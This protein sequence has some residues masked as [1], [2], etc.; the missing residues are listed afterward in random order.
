MSRT[1]STPSSVGSITSRKNCEA[2]EN[3]AIRRSQIDSVE[4][5][6]F[7]FEQQSAQLDFIVQE[8]EFLMWYDSII[9]I[10][11]DQKLSDLFQG[12]HSQTFNKVKKSL[13]PSPLLKLKACFFRQV[14][15]VPPQPVAAK[16]TVL[17]VAVHLNL[18]S[19]FTVVGVECF[20]HCTTLAPKWWVLFVAYNFQS[21][22]FIVCSY[23]KTS[24]LVNTIW[25]QFICPK[26]NGVIP[27]DIRNV[28]HLSPYLNSVPCLRTF[29]CYLEHHFSLKL[30]NF[31]MN[32]FF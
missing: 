25:A 2:C 30:H 31:R 21:L 12:T 20:Y 18:R 26:W 5:Q 4:R 29:T 15:I 7:T 14:D 6:K 10:K 27:R 23:L 24:A 9:I 13:W 17:Y 22:S 8:N 3:L 19:V 16:V 11:V 28:P 32:G 1:A